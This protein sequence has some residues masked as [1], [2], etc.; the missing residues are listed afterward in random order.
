MTQRPDRLAYLFQQYVTGKCSQV[1]ADEF[2]THA[3]DPACREELDALAYRYM[4][5]LSVPADV[6][7]IDWDNMY[8]RIIPPPPIVKPYRAHL[9][10]RLAA[11]AAVLVLLAAAGWWL[12]G[13][14]SRVPAP[15]Q[16]IHKVVPGGDRALLTLA[17][18]T[19]IPLDSAANGTLALQG[20]VTIQKLDSGGLA[21]SAA[22]GNADAA[23]TYNT[24][25]TPRGGQFRLTLPDGSR[26]WLNAASSIRYPTAFT[27]GERKVELTGEAYFEVEGNADMPF[28]VALQGGGEVRVLG[29]HF[30]INAYADEA[31]Q[32]TTLLEGAV[33]VTSAGSQKTLR[34]GQQAQVQPGNS[35][36]DIA[37]RD[38]DVEEVV[39]WKNGYFQFN[40]ADLGA[41]MRQIARW[42]DVEVSYEGRIPQRKF[43]GD[44]S[45]DAGIAEVLKVLESSSVRFRIEGKKII[46]TP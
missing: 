31:L 22:P 27:G 45:R 5:E 33:S 26:V 20:G 9:W 35:A 23:V 6:P 30:N 43:W 21:Y 40:Q 18:G 2:F 13:G 34:P 44:I 10:R 8:R 14:S 1:E 32:K 15:A 39:A 12:R 19:V 4:E 17:D 25:A 42:Y 41:V 24:L 3:G 7:A 29:T 11:A 28:R 38:T 46:V 16:A 37:V 36:G